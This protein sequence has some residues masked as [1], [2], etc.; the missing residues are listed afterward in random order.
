MKF[1]NKMT[2]FETLNLILYLL[3]L[4]FISFMSMDYYKS[5]IVYVFFL[6]FLGLYIFIEKYRTRIMWDFIKKNIE[7]TKNE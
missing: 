4:I 2:L 7:E 3:M 6:F 5:F 1:Y